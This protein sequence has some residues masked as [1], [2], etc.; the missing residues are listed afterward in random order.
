MTDPVPPPRFKATPYQPVGEHH[1]RCPICGH[2]V[3]EID[4]EEVM[5]HLDPVH[6]APTKN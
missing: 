4:L 6:D 2:M 3:D 5:Q 1:C